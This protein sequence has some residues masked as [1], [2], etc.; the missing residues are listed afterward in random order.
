M[1]KLLLID[2]DEVFVAILSRALQRRGHQTQVVQNGSEALVAL[3]R[4]AYDGCVL[5]LRLAHES[6]L[7]L[8]PD[9]LERAPDLR[10][11]VLTGYASL[12]TAVAAIKSGACN[13]LAKPASADEIM[14]A[15]SLTAV[16]KPELTEDP[17][18]VGRL[19]WEHLQRVL[20][21][22]E[23]NISATARSLKMHRR[24]LQRKLAKKPVQ[25]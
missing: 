14:Q 25:A 12:A 22:H 9:L 17:M 15:L 4:Q 21:Q 24:T 8:L 1:M 7:N 6:G 23:G 11:L 5:D 16:S 19:E 13:Y 2:D 18:S 3:Q 10:I 20:A